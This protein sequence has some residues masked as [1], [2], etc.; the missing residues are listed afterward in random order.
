[1]KKE[2][3]SNST[4]TIHV[5]WSVSRKTDAKDFSGIT[6][7][8]RD[9]KLP[10]YIDGKFNPKRQE[11]VNMLSA[12]NTTNSNTAVLLRN[13]IPKFLKVTSRITDVVPQLMRTPHL[14]KSNYSIIFNG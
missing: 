8:Q 14:S 2:L 3:E 12:E 6:T 11:L 4:V 5:E 1:M 10:A 13:A 9:I 7:T